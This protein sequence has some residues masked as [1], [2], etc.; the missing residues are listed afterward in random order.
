MSYITCCFPDGVYGCYY[1][2]DLII[3]SSL[4]DQY[5]IFTN[6]KATTLSKLLHKGTKS[7]GSLN[8]NSF[9]KFLLEKKII[10]LGYTKNNPSII[11]PKK[12]NQSG[13]EHIEWYLEENALAYKPKYSTVMYTYFVL[14]KTI[15]NLKK[16]GLYSLILEFRKLKSSNMHR[17]VN[18]NLAKIHTFASTLNKI[19]YYSL[20]EVK[21]LE[22]SLVLTNLL[23]REGLNPK[24]TI[25]V[26]NI[27]F[28]AHAWVELDGEII[29]DD[30]SLP[31]NLS[32]I[33]Q[34]P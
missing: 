9:T 32:V 31:N 4:L 34:E 22:W 12:V 28:K 15:Y 8:G 26:Q 5:F 20:W 13:T 25:G 17:P 27:P 24:L 11:L 19:C 21:C 33:L 23:L 10:E 14:F 29:Q 16:N 2:N 6:S 30:S 1:N 3:L 7:I 18:K